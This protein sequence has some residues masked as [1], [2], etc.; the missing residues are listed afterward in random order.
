MFYNLFKVIIF[1]AFLSC[2]SDS[3]IYIPLDVRHQST[4]GNGLFSYDGYRFSEY[5]NT[6]KQR[7]VQTGYQSLLGNQYAIDAMLPFVLYPDYTCQVTPADKYSKAIVLIHGLGD[8]PYFMKS[9]GEYF[10]NRC[11][12]VLS[13]LLPGHG[14]K[15]GDLI[16]TSWREWEKAQEFGVV[17]AKLQAE[18]VYLAGFSEGATLI[19]NTVAGRKDFAGVMLFAP[20]LNSNF[21]EAFAKF[22]RYF[23]FISSRLSWKRIGF[24]DA[25]FSYQSIHLN[26]IAQRRA[27]VLETKKKLKKYGVKIP[28]FMAVSWEDKNIDVAR[29]TEW[30]HHLQQEEKQLLFFSERR[31]L[32][33]EITKAKELHQSSKELQGISHVGIIM[34]PYD[35]IYGENGSYFACT[36]YLNNKKNYR[37]C[38]AGL[39]QVAGSKFDNDKKQVI[40]EELTY[41]PWWDITKEEIDKFLQRHE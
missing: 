28:I 17:Q 25:P 9:L 21:L 18:N 3:Q 32:N 23:N 10:Q 41:N 6:L 26:A 15:P 40:S 16:N 30:L 14:T 4:P 11:F 29:S 20:H 35:P 39:A 27:L 1:C 34:S 24:D 7:I 8:S 22:H 2:S 5:I 19:L 13:I 31:S 33:K 38:K 12:L 36:H 37:Q